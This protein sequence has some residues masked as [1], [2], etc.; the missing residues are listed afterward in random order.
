[1]GLGCSPDQRGWTQ[2]A[3]AIASW[4]SQ[5]V[6][7]AVDSYPQ[8]LFIACRQA[9]KFTLTTATCCTAGTVG[10]RIQLVVN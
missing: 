10:A 9:A 6:A 3:V 5:G 1:M 2:F 8:Q 4:V 7:N